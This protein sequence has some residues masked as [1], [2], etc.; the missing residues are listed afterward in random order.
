MPIFQST[1][2]EALTHRYTITTITLSVGKYLLSAILVW[3]VAKKHHFGE[4][5]KEFFAPISGK[6]A[7]LFK[8]T[9]A[10]PQKDKTQTDASTVKGEDEGTVKES[11]LRKTSGGAKTVV[12]GGTQQVAADIV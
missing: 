1:D 12:E 4:R 8:I 10:R 7:S 3:V 5:L 2:T 11:G 6:L 9:E